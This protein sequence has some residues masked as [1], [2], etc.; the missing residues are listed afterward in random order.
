MTKHDDKVVAMLN[1]TELALLVASTF[2]L[3]GWPFERSQAKAMVTA[4]IRRRADEVNEA[5]SAQARTAWD[6]ASVWKSPTG[7]WTPDLIRRRS[8]VSAALALTKEDLEVAILALRATHAEF[9]TNWDEFCVATPGNIDWYP[10][11]PESLADLATKLEQL[12][13]PT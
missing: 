1:G 2:A 9:E 7:F 4:P 11:S 5:V 10:A 3:F 6:D 8:L 12:V 13:S